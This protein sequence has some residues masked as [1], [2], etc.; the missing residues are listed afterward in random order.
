MKT[1]LRALAKQNGFDDCRFAKAA[2]AP[3]AKEYFSWLQA[4]RHGEMTWLARDPERRA[5]PAQVLPG[6]KTVVVLAANYF[7][8]ASARAEKGQIARYAWGADYH[9]IMLQNMVPID[10][11]L[12]ENGG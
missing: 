2:Q 9:H 6:A 3:H 5:N 4:G 1:T 7:Q 8:G 12:Q 11:F 10:A